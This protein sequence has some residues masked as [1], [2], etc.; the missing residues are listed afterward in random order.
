M[1][2]E[3]NIW[4]K[5]SGSPTRISAGGTLEQLTKMAQAFIARAPD[6]VVWGSD[7]PHSDVFEPGDM[8]NDGDLM[9]MVQ[10]FAPDEA[11][12]RRSSPRIPHGWRIS[13]EIGLRREGSMAA[14]NMTRAGLA[15]IAMLALVLA[16]IG[17]RAAA[18][19]TVR[20]GTSAIGS[21]IFE[22]LDVGSGAGIFAKHDI[23]IERTDF[24]G[25]GQLAQGI[26]AGAVDIAL[27]GSTDLVFIAKGMPAK[28]VTMR[29]R[30]RPSIS[31]SR[32]ARTER[33]SNPSS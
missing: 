7:W 17:S 25:G 24:A 14:M 8:P 33:S 16:C 21:Y 1:L 22:L 15:S 27:S 31:R 12:R 9:N 18:A 3:P 29:F 4:I 13:V 30:P 11:T 26:S 28:A 19:E 20:V 10:G 32:F 5:V 2:G 6:R 23:K